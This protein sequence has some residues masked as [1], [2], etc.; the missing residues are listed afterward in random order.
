MREFLLG[1][2]IGL[3]LGLVI[4]LAFN[5]RMLRGVRLRLGE[6]DQALGLLKAELRKLRR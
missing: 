6:L 5:L 3:P 1:L 2:A 4:A